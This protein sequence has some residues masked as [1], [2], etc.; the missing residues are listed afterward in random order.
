MTPIELLI[1]MFITANPVCY[2][3]QAT[4]TQLGRIEYRQLNWSCN[5]Q[6]W[7]AWA[8]KCP[9][10]DYFGH[11]FYVQEKRT[12]QAIYM[13]RFGGVLISVGAQLEDMWVPGCGS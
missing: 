9:D 11:I 3:H 8:R 7:Q 12:Q 2:A 1:A 5:E 6:D 10:G 13:D 4:Y